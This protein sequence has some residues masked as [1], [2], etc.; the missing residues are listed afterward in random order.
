MRRHVPQEVGAERAKQQAQSL[1]CPLEAI[2]N[3]A[4]RGGKKGQLGRCQRDRKLPKGTLRFVISLPFLS[5]CLFLFTFSLQSLYHT[6][7]S[8]YKIK[9][10]PKSHF[11]ED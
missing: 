3:E 11:G 10:V 4:M 7:P 5:F 6:L 2:H 9:I 1:S 8:S